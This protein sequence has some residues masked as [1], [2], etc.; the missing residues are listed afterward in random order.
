[1]QAL[2]APGAAFMPSE[3]CVM[4]AVAYWGAESVAA[5]ICGPPFTRVRTYEAIKKLIRT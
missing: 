3:V 5:A 2:A 1:M 4:A